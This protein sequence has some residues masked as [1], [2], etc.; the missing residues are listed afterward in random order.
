MSTSCRAMLQYWD[1][2]GMHHHSCFDI[3]QD[4]VLYALLG[5][6]KHVHLVPDHTRV[7]PVDYGFPGGS[8]HFAGWDDYWFNCHEIKHVS[9]LAVERVY[10]AR[11]SE[12]EEVA[13]AV[14]RLVALFGPFFAERGLHDDR[15]RYFAPLIYLTCGF[16]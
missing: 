8:V 4:L 10:R 1:E 15:S 11:R 3:D 12:T 5:S 2:A 9:W 16:Y 7:S 13:E 14:A 6:T